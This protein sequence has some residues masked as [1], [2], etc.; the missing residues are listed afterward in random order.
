MKPIVS[1]RAFLAG[2][3]ASGALLPLLPSE[4]AHGQAA[5]VPKRLLVVSWSN[6][7]VMDAWRPKG[8]ESAFTLGDILSPFEKL[9]SKLTV[10]DGLG[11]RVHYEAN[12]GALGWGKEQWFGGHDANPG[13]LTGV[14][15]AA[16][17]DNY[18]TSGG[19][20]IDQYVATELAK[21][22]N[23]PLRSV[24]VGPWSSGGY[25]GTISYKGSS[26]GITPESDPF[27]LFKTM[28]AGRALPMGQFDKGRAAR[29]SVIDY[30]GGNLTNFSSRMGTEDKA[31]IE[32]HLAAVREIERQLESNVT[33]TCKAPTLPD[34]F[35]TKNN[36]ANYPKA[37]KVFGDLLVAGFRCDLTRVASLV[38]SDVGGDDLVFS[39]LG[40]EFTGSGDEYPLRQYHDITHNQ[41]RSAEHKRRKIRVEQWFFE[42]V[43][44]IAEQLEATPEGTG[45]MLD[46]TLIVVTNTMGSNH[47]SKIQPFTLIGNLGGYFKTGRSLK[48]PVTGGLG[49]AHNQLLVS[50][51]NAMGVNGAAFGAPKYAQELAG[52]KA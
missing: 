7:Y 27:N 51:A 35:D 48:Y 21:T 29:K 19:D 45:T 6:G 16:Y 12:A 33:L 40:D 2:L 34:A 39:W 41:D 49:T 1:R 37:L 9:K 24:V 11:Q 14:P 23:L 25:G 52:L 5:A 43:A 8:N 28:F 50:I 4:Q 26:T 10:I 31:K 47:D 38:L 44:Y 42:Q 13:V 22:T 15:C 3:G 20:S 46:N 17:R 32:S 30:L 18:E 36:V